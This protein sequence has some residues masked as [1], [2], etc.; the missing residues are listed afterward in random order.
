MSSAVDRGL[1]TLILETR[2]EKILSDGVKYV[3]EWMSGTNIRAGKGMLIWPDGS[4]YEGWWKDN[5]ANGRGRLIHVDG[6]MYQ[7]GWMNDF[8]HGQ[9]VYYHLNGTKYDGEWFENE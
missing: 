9:G 4:V 5:K 2:P 3:G 7:G 6:S 8:C 1:A